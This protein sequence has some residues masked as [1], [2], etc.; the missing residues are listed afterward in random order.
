V[1]V[2]FDFLKRPPPAP[3]KRGP[4]HSG[5]TILV[6]T[7]AGHLNCTIE[8]ILRM[9]E[10]GE[11]RLDRAD[12]RLVLDDVID[13]Q[14]RRATVNINVDS[15]L[16]HREEERIFARTRSMQVGSQHRTWRP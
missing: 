13:L 14:T 6:A 4:R 15:W 9:V 5:R 11:L 10:R 7:A 12:G 8:E 2:F 3:P 16:H 1:T